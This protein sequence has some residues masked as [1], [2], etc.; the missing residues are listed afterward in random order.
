MKVTAN[1]KPRPKKRHQ[2]PT[3]DQ[4]RYTPSFVF[5]GI[6][7]AWEGSDWFQASYVKSDGTEILRQ[8]L[9]IETKKQMEA[10]KQKRFDWVMKKVI[11]N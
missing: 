4:D 7:I 11:V 2:C 6:I 9:L 5:H 1:S 3:H 8:Q 10:K